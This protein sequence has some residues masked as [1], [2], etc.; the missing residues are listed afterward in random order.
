M[1]TLNHPPQKKK[2]SHGFHARQPYDDKKAKKQK[3]K[4]H[5]KG[6]KGGGGGHVPPVPPSGSA[7]AHLYTLSFLYMK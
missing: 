1:M 2:L 7:P 6:R 5:K 3:K 4:N